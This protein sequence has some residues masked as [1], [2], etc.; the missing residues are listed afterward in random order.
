LA[1]YVGARAEFVKVDVTKLEDVAVEFEVGSLPAFYIFKTGVKVDAFT[2]SAVTA[3][4]TKICS[5]L[6]M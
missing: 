3:V 2:S 1:T 6:D 4:A 5:A